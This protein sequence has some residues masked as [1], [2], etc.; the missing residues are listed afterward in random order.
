MADALLVADQHVDEGFL[1]LASPLPARGVQSIPD[2]QTL[3]AWSFLHTNNSND[4][5]DDDAT[6]LWAHLSGARRA[7]ANLGQVRQR[8]EKDRL[9]R[10]ERQ[11]LSENRHRF[12]G[13]WIALEG[14]QLLAH[15]AT[16]REVFLKVSGRAT[17]P[18][19]ILVADE[20]LPFAGR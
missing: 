9:L 20:D 12:S 8:A 16:S 10:Q 5:L 6:T 4:R 19:V 3:P 15:G 11:W 18:L 17:P 2:S 1:A 14:D 7:L 13:R